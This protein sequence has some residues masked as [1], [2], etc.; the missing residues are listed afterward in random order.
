MP[1]AR[2]RL[3]LIVNPIAGMGGKVGLKGT[4]GMGVLRRAI[5]L[6]ARPEAP[7][8]TMAALE[9]LV[10][11]R[12]DFEILTYPLDMGENQAKALG[13]ETVVIN[14][15]AGSGKIADERGLVNNGEAGNEGEAANESEV[16]GSQIDV[17]STTFQDT[18][19]AA[20]D[21]LEAG[22]D[23]I[24]FAGGD[25]T[26]RNI[27]NAVGDK[28]PVL[29]ISAGVK[30]HSPVYATNPRSAGQLAAKFLKGEITAVREAEVMDIDE[31][32]FREGRVTPRLYGYLRVPHEERLMQNLKSGSV[33]SEAA[34][35]DG[36]A[37][38]IVEEMEPDVLYI[39]GPG[40][41][42]RPV[43]EKLGLKATLLGVDVVLD[44]KLVV[45]DAGE[46][47]LL[48]L[49]NLVEG[50]GVAD[51]LERTAGAP[52]DACSRAGET[53]ANSIDTCRVAGGTGGGCGESADESLARARRAQII[54]TVIG[55]QGYVFGRGNQQLSPEVIRK[56]GTDN[57]RIIAT[58]DKLN[59]LD[60]RPLLVDTG[61]D[62]LNQALSGY[63]RVLV[64][65]GR[66]VMYRIG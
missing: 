27:Y 26:A 34:A 14:Q 41:T 10:P 60:R 20:R 59:A 18:E 58:R 22:A 48:Q 24:L 11:L 46:Q 45:A 38:R 65:Y 25:G 6:G 1:V 52:V 31:D 12:D 39:I 37:D 35:L 32:A 9:V 13:F 66:E 53:E 4:D 54:V 64:S 2:K 28:V 33:E 40:T 16:A 55:G 17:S 7:K 3:G 62:D 29:G 61:D 36:I 30:I 19:D 50:A 21:M 42:T 49:L 56:V 5:E 47:D 23:L 15:I 44:G 43:M 57:I 8:R 63:A 51:G